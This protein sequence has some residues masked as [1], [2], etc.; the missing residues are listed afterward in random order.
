MLEYLKYIEL[1]LLI[2][3]GILLFSIIEIK[4]SLMKFKIKL[5]TNKEIGIILTIGIVV[6]ITIII[7][8]LN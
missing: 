6:I 1:L 7:Y 5:I 8:N 3:I 4:Y 2:G